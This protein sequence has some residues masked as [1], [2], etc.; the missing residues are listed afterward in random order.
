M[1]CTAFCCV[2]IRRPVGATL[3][4][5][6][7]FLL[8]AVAYNFLPVTS[9]PTIDFPTIN[10]SASLPGADPETMAKTV[11]APLERQLAKIADVTEITSTSSIG[12]TNIALQFDLNRSIDHAARD[13]QSA[14]NA[15]LNALPRDLPT[16]PYFGKFNPASEPIL[17]FALTSDTMTA[18][19]IYDVA[20]VM[21]AQRISRVEGVAAV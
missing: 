19:A 12:S 11:A 8:G 6:G 7:L 3:I 1:R 17:S 16:R 2:F 4:A 15:A 20:D 18:S 13:V 9:L 10:V 14:L 5:I 21:I